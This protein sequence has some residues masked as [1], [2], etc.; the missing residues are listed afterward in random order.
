MVGPQ[1]DGTPARGYNSLQVSPYVALSNAE[2]LTKNVLDSELLILPTS[3]TRFYFPG[4]P[5][6]W[7]CPRAVWLSCGLFRDVLTACP[8]VLLR[9][10]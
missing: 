4:Y 2:S 10:R 9:A 1:V 6:R 8:F 7:V 3:S 5:L